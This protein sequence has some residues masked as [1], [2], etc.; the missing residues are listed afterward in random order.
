MKSRKHGN[1]SRNHI[2]EVRLNNN[3]LNVDAHYDKSKYRKHERGREE[4]KK[5]VKKEK[6]RKE[7][8]SQKNHV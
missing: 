4:G 6:K 2:S 3:R 1:T 7:K 8:E 5:Y